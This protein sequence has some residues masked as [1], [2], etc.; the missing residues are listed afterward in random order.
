MGTGDL[1]V[2]SIPRTVIR[3]TQ[4]W[5]KLSDDMAA[6]LVAQWFGNNRGART[7]KARA[8]HSTQASTIIINA[9]VFPSGSDRGVNVPSA[10]TAIKSKQRPLIRKNHSDLKIKELVLRM[11]Q[12]SAKAVHMLS[13]KSLNPLIT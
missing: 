12:I 11:M 3:P 8:F 2:G 1:R 4:L 5:P 10:A 7:P 6:P 9:K 13:L